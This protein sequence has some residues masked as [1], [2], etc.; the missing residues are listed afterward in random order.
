MVFLCAA[1][2]SGKADAHSASLSAASAIAI[3][4]QQQAN[5]EYDDNE[6]DIGI[7]N[8][9]IDLDADIEKTNEAGGGM[10]TNAAQQATAG[11]GAGAKQAAKM[12]IEHSATVDKVTTLAC[13][14][15]QQRKRK[16]EQANF[17]S[18]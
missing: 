1:G 4:Q 5:F 12:A 6:W 14:S 7:G 9:I 2:I 10:A 18:S 3:Q 17:A 13:K 8:L 16:F 11:P 15:E